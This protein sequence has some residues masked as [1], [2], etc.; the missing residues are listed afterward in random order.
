MPKA[1]VTVIDIGS[2]SIRVLIASHG[3]V[4]ALSVCGYAECEYGGYYEGEFLEE[5]KL[6]DVFSKALMNAQSVANFYVDKVY[7]G[8]PAN[9]TFCKTK[10][11][12]QNFGQKVRILDEDIAQI[13]TMADDLKN[14]D[15]VLI[16][17]TPIA[18][19]LD[20]GTT[21]VTPVG[22]KSNKLTA[23]VSLIYAERSF[24]EKIN[25]ILKNIGVGSV[26]YLSSTLCEDLYLL[27]KE[28]RAEPNVVID[29]GYIETSV[30]IVQGEGLWD[31]KSFAVGGGH[32]SADLMECLD[33]TFEEAEQLRKKLVL[34]VNAGDDDDYEI[35]RGGNIVP[36]SMKKAND[37]TYA[38]LEMMSQLIQKCIRTDDDTLPYYLTGGGISYIKGAKEIL[39]SCL[40]KNVNILYPK[41]LHLNKPHYSALLGMAEYVISTKQDEKEKSFISRLLEKIIKR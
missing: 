39:S 9:F 30:S 22:K 27:S 19:E 15:Y 24:I 5:D 20:D 13:Y 8:V 18:F 6:Q 31:L 28:R 7:V 23:T 40:D 34:S 37:I 33:I 25:S 12:T 10:T 38:R 14:P 11:L 29:C 36:I 26:E 4:N 17:A 2:K 21:T 35:S 41:D 16:S 32:I 1:K 3:T